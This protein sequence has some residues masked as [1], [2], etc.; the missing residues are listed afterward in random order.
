MAVERRPLSSDGGVTIT[1]RE[2][3]ALLDQMR[4]DVAALKLA[5][6]DNRLKSLER[7]KWGMLA[8]GVSSGSSMTAFLQHLLG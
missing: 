8:L 7:W 5:D 4:S 6:I 2:V 1:M 3:W